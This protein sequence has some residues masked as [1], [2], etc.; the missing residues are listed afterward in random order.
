MNVTRG[1]HECFEENAVNVRGGGTAV[2]VSREN[3]SE[4]KEEGN[5]S[6]CREIEV[7]YSKGKYVEL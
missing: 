5:C 7:D 1:C 6:E 2:N 3:C 4:C